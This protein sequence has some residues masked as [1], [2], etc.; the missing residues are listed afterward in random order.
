MSSCCFGGV[1]EPVVRSCG[2]GKD[3]GHIAFFGVQVG[4]ACGR[5]AEGVVIK[6]GVSEKKRS[7]CK[8]STK[9]SVET[10]TMVYQSAL[11][12]N[13]VPCRYQCSLSFPF[14]TVVPRWIF[15]ILFHRV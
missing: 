7:D 13:Q 2:A 10:P 12:G 6:E 9:A 8:Q 5:N 1:M 3:G 15:A 4:A 11:V 14:H